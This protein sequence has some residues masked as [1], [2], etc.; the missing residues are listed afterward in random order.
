MNFIRATLLTALLGLLALL[1]AWGLRPSRTAPSREGL[2][3]TPVEAVKKTA[4]A[5]KRD[6]PRKPPA[7]DSVFADPPAQDGPD[8]PHPWA[9]YLKR[10]EEIEAKLRGVTL[11]LDFQDAD[12]NEMIPELEARIG[13]K[14]HLDVPADI[15]AKKISFCV[16]DLAGLHVLRLL[17]QQYDLQQVVSED[18]ELWIVATGEMPPD[19]GDPVVWP[20]E[21]AF[22]AD[23][24]RFRAA[25]REFAPKPPIN[26]ANAQ[27]EV[28]LKDA[29][30]TK[31]VSLTFTDTSLPEA[32]SFFQELTNLNVMVDRRWIDDPDAV[33][34]NTNVSDVT[35]GEALNGCL[36]PLELGFYT[37]EG[38]LVVTSQKQIDQMQA[39]E[40]LAAKTRRDIASVEKDLFAQP[41]AFGAE[42]MRLRDVADILAKGLGVPY[43]IDPGTWSR[44]ARY[45][46]E[47]RQRPASEIVTLLKKGAPLIVAYRNG[48]LWFLSPEGIK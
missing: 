44:K 36:K 26:E 23:I 46:I 42:N 40:E 48:I 24:R 10:C 7:Q 13:M 27:N 38:M 20:H 2:A 22:I 41:V 19:G 11:V 18:G 31:K 25:S 15:A 1:I 14:L 30:K 39:A 29:M 33:I 8:A 45:T 37:R 28:S 32:V 43:Q 17:I 4:A 47:E 35:L 21:P 9:A 3:A 34:V 6:F 5:P 12:L 16:K